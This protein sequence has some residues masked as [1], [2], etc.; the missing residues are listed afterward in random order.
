MGVPEK[1]QSVIH[2]VLKALIPY[3]DQ[4]LKLV[5]QPGRFFYDLEKITF[6]NRQ[7]LK[8]TLSRA[9]KSGYI[10]M[11][12]GAPMLTQKGREKLGQLQK[13]D[14]LAGWLLVSFDVP[15][16]RRHDRYAL[17]RYLK[18]RDFRQL[19]K[20]LWYSPY[21]YAEDLREVIAELR[22]G[23]HVCIFAAASIYAPGLNDIA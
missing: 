7:T 21:D 2:E 11:K 18:L 23:A 16:A 22:L 12:S 1:R 3:T 5:F 20:S 14:L 4:N 8:T 17:R 19:Q 13:P 10:E 15:E 6:A 9:K